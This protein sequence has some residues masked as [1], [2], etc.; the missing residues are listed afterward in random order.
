M[1]S[2]KF[3]PMVVLLICL[4]LLSDFELW[5]WLMMVMETL[6]MLMM[7]MTM[8]VNITRAGPVCSSDSIGAQGLKEGLGDVEPSSYSTA[9]LAGSSR[10]RGYVLRPLVCAVKQLQRYDLATSPETPESNIQYLRTGKVRCSMNVAEG[11]RSPSWLA[12]RPTPTW[13]QNIQTPCAL[14]PSAAVP[15]LAFLQRPQGSDV[16][17]SELGTAAILKPI[18]RGSAASQAPL[19]PLHLRV[20]T[21]TGTTRSSAQLINP[22]WPE[23]LE[24]LR[25]IVVSLSHLGPA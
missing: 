5:I 14:D 12:G 13:A 18:G 25:F 15:S 6:M 4:K 16:C 2:K 1:F 10:Q 19:T 23:D 22:T 20:S 24:I 8:I 9:L 11:H 17:I 3:L 7:T 21:T